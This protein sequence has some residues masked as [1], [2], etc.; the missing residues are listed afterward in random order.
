MS[1][2]GDKILSRYKFRNHWN[3]GQ[4]LSTRGRRD[5]SEKAQKENKEVDQGIRAQR[6]PRQGSKRQKQD[7]VI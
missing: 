2:S 3:I 4:N 7:K 5:Y 1:N 6:R